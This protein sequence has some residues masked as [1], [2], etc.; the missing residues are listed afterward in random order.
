MFTLFFALRLNSGMSASKKLSLHHNFFKPITKRVL[1]Y[2]IRFLFCVIFIISAALLVLN[3]WLVPRINEYRPSIEVYLSELINAPVSIRQIRAF[4]FG[5]LPEIELD[6]LQISNPDGSNGLLIERVRASI[7]AKALIQFQLRLHEITL[8]QPQLFIQ[9]HNDGHLWIAGIDVT[10]FAAAKTPLQADQ[11]TPYEVPPVV[12]W[13]L[14]QH[15]INIRQGIARWL[16]QTTH[17]PEF[18]LRD[19]EATLRS[20]GGYDHEIRIEATP[21]HSWGEKFTLEFILTEP[22]WTTAAHPLNWN[23]TAHITFPQVNI[24]RLPQYIQLPIELIQGTGFLDITGI[25]KDGELTESQATFNMPDIEIITQQNLAPIHLQDF[26]G[27]ITGTWQQNTLRIQTPDLAFRLTPTEAVSDNIDKPLVWQPSLLDTSWHFNEQGILNGGELKTGEINLPTLSLLAL[28][29]PLPE[30]AHNL[31]L[32]MNTQGQIQSL[33]FQWQG[34]IQTPTYYA[35]KG[36]LQNISVIA[37]GVPPIPPGKKIAVGR[38]GVDGLGLS[39][40]VSQGQGIFELNITNGSITLPGLYDAPEVQVNHLTAS[41]LLNQI[42]DRQI[43]INV[44]NLNLTAP[45]GKLGAQMYWIS[46]DPQNPDDKAGYFSMNGIL[47]DGQ[48]E[49]VHRYLPNSIQSKVRDYLKAA[50]ISGTVPQA[51]VLVEGPLVDFPYHQNATGTFLIAGNVQ[52]ATYAFA[53]PVVQPPGQAPWPVL[54]QINGYALFTGK[55]MR[56]MH[57]TGKIQNAPN[58]FFTVKEASIPNWVLHDTHVLVNATITG[59]AN[60]LLEVVNESAIGKN[61]LKGLLVLAQASGKL[62]SQLTLDI[63]LDHM[64]DTT[65]TG[66]IKFENNKIS[67][68]PF[69]PQLQN[70]HGLLTYTEKGFQANQVLAQTLGGEVRGNIQMDLEQGLE[71]NLQGNMTALGLA[72]DPHWGKI[73]LPDMNWLSGQTAYTFNAHYDDGQQTMLWSS[74]LAGLAMDLPSPLYKPAD[75]AY[76]VQVRLTPLPANRQFLPMLIEVRADAQPVG[77]PEIRAS[78]VLDDDSGQVQITQ[79]VLGINTNPSMPLTGTSASIVLNTLDIMQWQDFIKRHLPES[80]SSRYPRLQASN[81]I[82]PIWWPQQITA[83]IDDLQ[84]TQQLNTQ[85]AHIEI[86]RQN[87]NWQA[88]IRSTDIAG[89]MEWQTDNAHDADA[90][91][92]SAQFSRLWIATTSTQPRQNDLLS[93]KARSLSDNIFTLLPNLNLRINH[94]RL[95]QMNLGTLSMQAS[96]DNTVSGTRW[97][98]ENLSLVSGSSKLEASGYWSQTPTTS[99]SIDLQLQTQDSGELLELLGHNRLIANAAGVLQGHLS[100]QA[101]PYDIDIKTLNGHLNVNLQKGAILFVNAGA[102]RVFNALSLQSLPNRLAL[103][104]RDL[105]D[106]GLTFDEVNSEMIIE[107]GIIDLHTLNLDGVSAKVQ[108]TGQLDLVAQ[109]QDLEVIVSPQFDMGA[110]SLAVAAVNPIAG[111]GSLVAQ[112]VLKMPLQQMAMRTYYVYGSWEK[113]I[114]SNTPPVS[115]QQSLPPKSKDSRASSPE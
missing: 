48:A 17:A 111:I 83:D 46:P 34:P 1:C 20:S 107:N 70:A 38:P 100:W 30:I 55:G 91:K 60:E 42:N 24:Q 19:I 112:M 5:L 54:T 95:D 76:P 59:P 31:L 35:L 101:M 90:G 106:S 47:T 77:L 28:G 36:E 93:E 9:R 23:A 74:N 21:P 97:Q 86:Q 37:G 98:I 25:F 88:E 85:N 64:P 7:S 3:F 43:Q 10:A 57:T 104:F 89:Q 62:E 69:V 87:D 4:H 53:P 108:L 82:L 29:L 84:L 2:V 96:I 78:Y 94:F 105:I 13:L 27:N 6:N 72:H 15:Q 102:G 114:V 52:N 50:L 12:L 16:D 65:V 71:I 68:W 109:T 26:K 51:T 115:V 41:A 49:F 79:G 75:L 61:V 92:L 80:L 99:T 33:D 18:E 113:P 56:I 45:G 110:A 103:D 58:S 8:E 22:T 73:L 32:E 44:P 40:S 14:R 81:L 63:T 67:L 39:F 11:T 66:S